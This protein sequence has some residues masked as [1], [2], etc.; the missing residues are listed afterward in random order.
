MALIQADSK[1]KRAQLTIEIDRKTNATLKKYARYSRADPN[2]IVIGALQRLFE[3]D[4]EF[5]PW[6]ERREQGKTKP[7]HTE[8]T[9]PESDQ[10]TSIVD[11]GI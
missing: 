3:Q 10:P 1:G 2:E 11:H 4:P 7:T 8:L 9:K 5:G 6:L